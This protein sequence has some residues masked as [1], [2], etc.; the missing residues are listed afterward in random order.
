VRCQLTSTN[1][2]SPNDFGTARTGPDAATGSGSPYA[3]ATA[4]ALAT[5]V[6]AVPRC[7]AQNVPSRV[8][9]LRRRFPRWQLRTVVQVRPD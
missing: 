9:Q 6:R 8:L 3:P 2:P 7:L 1:I 4:Q 5:L